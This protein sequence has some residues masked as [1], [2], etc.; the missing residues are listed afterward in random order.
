MPHILLVAAHAGEVEELKSLLSRLRH[1]VSVAE[2][3][4][5]ALTRLERSHPDLVVVWA[6]TGD[7]PGEEL[8]SI[9]RGDPA[10]ENVRVVLL[11]ADG[12][13]GPLLSEVRTIPLSSTPPE[14]AAAIHGFLGLQPPEEP[15]SREGG[16]LSPILASPSA[17]GGFGGELDMIRAATLVQTIAHGGL[18][19]CLHLF[20]GSTEGKVYFWGGRVIHAKLGILS[21]EL[22]FEV[23]IADAEECVNASFRFD[24]CDVRK[25]LEVPETIS[26]KMHVMLLGAAALLGRR[27]EKKDEE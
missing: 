1:T 21:G 7:M 14:I 16:P 25:I 26:S 18:T 27:H 3:G 23:M 10:M 6:D 11:H 24:P 13:P 4:F 17:P 19:G 9:A 15:G 22:A 2:G 8:C 12:Q 20:F 5:Y